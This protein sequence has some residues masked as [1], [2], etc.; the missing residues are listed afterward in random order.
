M[1]NKNQDYKAQK[2]LLSSTKREQNLHFWKGRLQAR[3]EEDEE[4]GG[5]WEVARE[6][7][8]MRRIDIE[9]DNLEKCAQMQSNIMAILFVD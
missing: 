1:I 7:Y 6:Y 8:N 2:N 9:N 5:D 3:Y 4:T